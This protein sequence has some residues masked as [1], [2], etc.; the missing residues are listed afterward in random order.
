MTGRLWL[1]MQEGDF[2]LCGRNGALSYYN[3]WTY[4]NKAYSYKDSQPLHCMFSCPYMG[5]FAD[6]ENVPAIVCIHF[7]YKFK[8]RFPYNVNFVSRNFKL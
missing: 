1:Y 5:T 3:L 4:L 8:L 2:F 6:F 7:Y